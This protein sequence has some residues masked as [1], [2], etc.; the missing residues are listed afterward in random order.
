MVRE[1]KVLN[2]AE[3]PSVARALAAVFQGLPG[4]ID[5]GMR[6][7]VH[8]IFTHESVHFVNV[9]VQGDGRILNGPSE[10]LFTTQSKKP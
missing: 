9:H 10:F 6:R 4:S 1:T 8:Q 7:D 5:R 3:K 2:V